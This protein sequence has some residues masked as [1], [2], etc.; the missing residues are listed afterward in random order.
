MIG[1]SIANAHFPWYCMSCSLH[2]LSL[3]LPIMFEWLG[4]PFPDSA[5]I[6]PTT[7]PQPGQ[8]F[9]EIGG[10]LLLCPRNALVIAIRQLFLVEALISCDHFD[11]QLGT[12]SVRTWKMN[13]EASEH[14]DFDIASA[15]AAFFNIDHMS[16]LRWFRHPFW[17]WWPWLCPCVTH[18]LHGE[19]MPPLLMRLRGC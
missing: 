8:A 17:S 10:N 18:C 14:E 2:D 12:N 7:A 9:T 16:F 1:R 5:I 6:G 19:T 11:V 15:I 4:W 13:K 3:R